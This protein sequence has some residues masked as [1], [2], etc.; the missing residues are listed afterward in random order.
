[1]IETWSEAHS[2][3]E[4]MSEDEADDIWE[5]MQAQP[6]APLTLK[7]ARAHANRAT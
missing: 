4:R 1:V 2:P 5:W 6:L 7:D 3:R